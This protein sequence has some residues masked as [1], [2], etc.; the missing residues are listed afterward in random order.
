MTDIV[1]IDGLEFIDSELHS[2][3]NRFF[4]NAIAADTIDLGGSHYHLSLES[5]ALAADTIVSVARVFAFTSNAVAAD[6]LAFAR[7]LQLSSAAV[8]QDTPSVKMKTAMA[9]TST[10]VASSVAAP[11]LVLALTSNAVAA[12]TLAMK[13]ILALHSDAIASAVAQSKILL[14][15]SSSATAADVV[16]ARKTLNLTSSGV[17]ADTLLSALR[18]VRIELASAAVAS[19][20]ITGNSNR[21]TIEL[22]SGAIALSAL[23]VTW[24]AHVSLESNAE[25]EDLVRLPAA[26]APGFW[27][28]TTTGAAATWEGLPFNS[29]VELNGE[30]YGAGADGLYQLVPEAKD[31]TARIDAHVFWDLSDFD[32]ANR[33]RLGGVY[34]AGFAEKGFKVHVVNRQGRF[35]YDTR[36]PAG[37]DA[38]NY[39]AR[40]GRGLDSRY[41]RIGVSSLGFFSVV[42]VIADYQRTARRI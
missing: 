35:V 2:F 38:T 1:H 8:A 39:R 12:D 19:D 23:G 20:A 15:L 13:R 33:K 3:A 22:Q 10:A 32:D 5:S 16:S 9:L 25:A 36:L 40:P 41:Y 14:A 17:A 24:H 7:V 31:G 4:S 29:M 37:E 30:V 6:V 21:V 18:L 28:N 42:G 11:H 26:G 34:V 27:S